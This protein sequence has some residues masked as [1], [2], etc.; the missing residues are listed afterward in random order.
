M[1]EGIAYI[2]GPEVTGQVRLCQTDRGVWIRAAIRG[3]P[4]DGF[5]GWHIHQGWACGGPG[6]SAA[7]DHF[8]LEGRLHPDHAGDLPPLLSCGGRACM[9]VLTDRF[10]LRDVIGRTMVVHRRPDDLHTQPSGRSG[11]RIGCGQIRLRR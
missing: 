9:A 7:G 8:D 10:R 6:F 5:F 1:R 2:R 4:E 3:L 11:E